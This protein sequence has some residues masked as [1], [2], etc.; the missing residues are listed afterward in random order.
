MKGCKLSKRFSTWAALALLAACANGAS[1]PAQSPVSNVLWFKAGFRCDRSYVCSAT[2]PSDSTVRSH[3]S[4]RGGADGACRTQEGYVVDRAGFL[5]TE[6]T[7]PMLLELRS[8][9]GKPPGLGELQC[10]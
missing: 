6:E 9:T 10:D 1:K 7:G 3:V 4:F 8:A 5:R 2:G